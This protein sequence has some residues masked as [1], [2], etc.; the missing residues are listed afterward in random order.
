M[1]SSVIFAIVSSVIALI[2]GL[3]LILNILKKP[4]GN[5]RM[6]EIAHA[7]QEGAKAY[8]NRQYKTI[9]V[10]AIVLFFIIWGTLGLE[11]S[12]GFLV[13]AIFSALAGYIGMNVSVR[14]NIRTAEAARNGLAVNGRLVQH[15]VLVI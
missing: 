6:R 3:I 7:I 12:I 11:T 8:L 14:T 15:Y 13:G 1:N 5:D 9:A 10:I 2:Y 4:T